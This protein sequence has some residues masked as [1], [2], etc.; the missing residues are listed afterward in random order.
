MDLTITKQ[1]ENPLLSRKEVQAKIVFEGATPNRVD[2]QKALAKSIKADEK[3]V[4][5]QTIQTSFGHSNATVVAHAYS[6]ENAMKANERANL[7]EK[8]AGHKEEPAAEASEE[9]Q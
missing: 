4:I 2:V 7:L 3:M 6:D 1:T 5:V 8:H 9:A